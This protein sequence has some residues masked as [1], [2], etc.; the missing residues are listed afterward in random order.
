MKK[1][2]IGWDPNAKDCKEELVSFLEKKGFD[3]V[4]FGGE[5]PIY[6]NVA[7]DVANAVADRKAIR[8]ILLCG[9]GI[10][11]SIAANKVKGAYAALI[12]DQYSAERSRLSND[13][14]VACFGAFTLGQ[15]LIESCALSFLTNEF[16]PNSSSKVKV[17]RFVE[18]DESR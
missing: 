2:A 15:R 14:N 17:E 1:I 6:A 11:M 4:D 13:A 10:G 9:T 8:G 7:F 3:I 16:D 5:D 18:F 12:A